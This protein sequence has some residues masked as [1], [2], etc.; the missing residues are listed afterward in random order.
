LTRA[1]QP[2]PLKDKSA[3][4]GALLSQKEKVVVS[5]MFCFA[6]LGWLFFKIAEQM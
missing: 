1:Y 5:V 4:A 2:K 3:I 6:A